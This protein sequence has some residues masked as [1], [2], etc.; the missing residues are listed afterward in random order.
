M[1]LMIVR[2]IWLGLH[3]LDTKF[4][5]DITFNIVYNVIIQLTPITYDMNEHFYPAS[6]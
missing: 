3:N 2:T 4:L 5:H 6:S 1:I